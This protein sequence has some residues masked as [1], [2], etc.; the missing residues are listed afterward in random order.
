MTIAPPPRIPFWSQSMP[1]LTNSHLIPVEMYKYS[2]TYPLILIRLPA[3]ILN[4]II[5]LLCPLDTALMI[6]IL[7]SLHLLHSSSLPVSHPAWWY[8]SKTVT[9]CHLYLVF[10]Y[11]YSLLIEKD[12][13]NHQSISVKLPCV[14][15]IRRFLH[16]L[17]RASS[18][19]SIF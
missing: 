15:F 1:N 3:A 16:F 5:N 2:I 8:F 9:W 4:L 12:I 14:L 18:F 6:S 17:V 10:T 11:I 13:C 7:F 19:F